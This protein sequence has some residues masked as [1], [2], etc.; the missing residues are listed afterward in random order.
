MIEVIGVLVAAVDREHATK[1]CT[2]RVG[3]R[4]CGITRAKLL[5][6]PRRRSPSPEASRPR[7]RS[8]DHIEGGCDFLGVNGWK[9]GNQNDIVS[10]GVEF[11]VEVDGVGFASESY[12]ALRFTLRSPASQAP[13]DGYDG[14]TTV[15]IATG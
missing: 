10:S 13:S 12:A 4:R 5:A 9:P 7:L 15:D 8:A 6:K 14:L 2:T 3:S 1:L 11:A